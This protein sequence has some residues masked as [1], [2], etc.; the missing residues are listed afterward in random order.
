MIILSILLVIA[1]GIFLFLKRPDFGRPPSKQR[2]QDFINSPNYKSNSFQNLSPTPALTEGASYT[3][4]MKNFLFNRNKN[5]I[6]PAP[7]PSQKTDLHALTPDENVLVWFGHSSYFLQLDGKKFLVDPVF[8]GNASPVPNSLKSFAGTDVY[9]TDDIPEIDYLII[10]HDHWD[11]LDHKTI[12]KLKK[13]IRHIYTGLGVGEHLEWWGFSKAMITEKDWN[14][15]IELAP[16]F[17][18]ITAPA[19]HFSGRSFKRNI[20]LWSSF[21]L[22][23]PSIKIYL[24]GDSG[25]DNHFRM[26]GHQQGP[27]DLVILECGQ[28]NKNWKYIHMMPEEVVL[29]AEDLAARNLMIVHWAKFPLSDHDWNEPGKKVAALAAQKGLPLATP[30]IGEK[31]DLMKTPYPMQLWWEKLEG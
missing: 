22:I 27:F 11:H 30:M 4:V 2:M 6:P 3:G 26:I 19:R 7:I 16:G 31:M 21:I 10:T 25:Y 13:K 23:T 12:T 1:T 28:Y 20:S 24:G 17:N 14:Q 8:S 29:A 15:T 5:R 9:T 18:L